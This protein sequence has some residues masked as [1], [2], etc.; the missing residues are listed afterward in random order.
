MNPFFHYGSHPTGAKSMKTT[1]R[2]A[3]FISCI[4]LQS[5]CWGVIPAYSA[6]M[7]APSAQIQEPCQVQPLAGWI[8][9]K[10]QPGDSLPILGIKVGNQVALIK[11]VNCISLDSLAVGSEIYLPA[12]P[13][14]TVPADYDLTPMATPAPLVISATPTTAPT[15]TATPQQT[16]TA[17][18]QQ[19]TVA[20]AV[21]ATLT[22]QPATPTA[23]ATK[24]STATATATATKTPTP[25]GTASPTSTP[26]HTATASAQQ[27]T[28]A[29]A[30]AA[31]LTAQPTTIA[32]TATKVSMPTATLSPTVTASPTSTAQ[33][34]ATAS[35]QQ[36]TVAQAVAATLTAQPT[37]E[38]AQISNA[39][40]IASPTEMPDYAATAIAQQTAV[41]QSVEA[42]IA[43]LPPATLPQSATTV[44]GLPNNSIANVLY[45]FMRNTLAV[46]LLL[47]TLLTGLFFAALHWWRFQY[48]EGTLRR[49]F[50]FLGYLL[51]LVAG[52]LIG[53]LIFPLFAPQFML[54]LPTLVSIIGAL[55]FLSILTLREATAH[56]EGEWESVHSLLNVASGLLL[57]AFFF[58]VALRFAEFVM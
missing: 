45:P 15:A 8:L 54:D 40:E 22:A 53:L 4:M 6:G 9:Y 49:S 2:L 43:A 57:M 32:A 34:T 44:G 19:T 11:K 56:L 14:V 46:S 5:I 20:Q 13:G 39:T 52:I 3:L 37:T 42:T 25:T 12:V 28:I 7:T 31:T 55:L 48:D 24:V 17:R 33:Q 29:Q 47:I 10:V 38:A 16:A 41:A 21:A 35:A 50:L 30:V 51:F 18:A 58:I 36:T 23:T 26:Q 1:L 27:T